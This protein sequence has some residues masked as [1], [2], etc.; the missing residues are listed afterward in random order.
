MRSAMLISKE[1]PP[2]NLSYLVDVDGFHVDGKFLPK[3]LAYCNM[4]TG[5][6]KLFRFKVGSMKRLSG[7]DRFQANWVQRHLH[8]LRFEDAPLDMPQSNVPAVLGV[9]CEEA[10]K[11]DH[12]IGYKGG[13]IEYDLLASLGFT[14]LAYNI[15]DLGCPRF[16]E[17]AAAATREDYLTNKVICTY[18]KPVQSKHD[19]TTT[20]TIP[21]CPSLEVQ[22]FRQYIIEKFF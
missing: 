4:K 18:H 5:D 19:K 16:D 13:H 7:R 9:I 17:L 2:Y 22:L 20:K 14:A 11:S 6:V 21:H 8:G 15:E 1:E 12:F 10:Y 3:E